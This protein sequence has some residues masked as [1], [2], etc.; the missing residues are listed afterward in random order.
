MELFETLPDRVTVDGKPYRIDLDFRNVF[1]ML[2]ILGRSEL[3]PAARDYLALKCVMKHPPKDTAAALAAIKD[4]IFPLEKRNEDYKKITDFSQDA[5]LIRA[6]FMQVYGINLFRD[7]LH[8]FE[9]ICLLHGLPDGNRYKDVLSIR[10]RPLPNPTKDNAEQRQWLIKAKAEYALKMTDKEQKNQYS[11]D[12]RGIALGL[13]A[14]A[15]S[16]GENA[17][18]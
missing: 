16:G 15:E 18:V 14:W 8:W 4:I 9:F 2:N 10:A 7:R 11:Q 6:A 1:R 12:V 3:T 13:I 17:D 5:D